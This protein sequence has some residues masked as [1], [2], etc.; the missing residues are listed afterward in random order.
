M[1]KTCDYCENTRIWISK[2]AFERSKFYEKFY[3]FIRLECED[4]MEGFLIGL[5]FHNRNRRI[6][7][8]KTKIKNEIC[9]SFCISIDFSFFHLFS[10]VIFPTLQNL[11]VLYN[12]TKNEE[13][14]VALLTCICRLST[15]NEFI[16]AGFMLNDYNY[17]YA[18]RKNR[19]QKVIPAYLDVK[20]VQRREKEK[21]EKCNFLCKTF[22][23]AFS[24]PD[25]FQ[26]SNIPLLKKSRHFLFLNIFFF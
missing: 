21:T 3:K 16:R 10:D 18:Q 11:S 26:H 5:F 17:D 24:R 22:K 6:S 2:K 8:I 9:D 14:R 15:F 4:N 25:L 7:Q 12:N 19:K 13:D 1:C 23:F 20:T